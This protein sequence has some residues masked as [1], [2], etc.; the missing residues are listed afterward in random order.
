[1]EQKKGLFLVL[2][3]GEGTGKTTQAK[4]LAEALQKMGHEVLLTKEP[5]GDEGVCRD[6]RKTLLNPDYKGGMSPRAELLLFEADRA[7]HV[8]LV[9][10]PALEAGKIA[11]CDRYEGATEAYQCG[12]RGLD[13]V[14]FREI[15]RFA[16][17]ELAPDFTFWVDIDPA[18]GLQRN[19][20]AQKRDRFELEDIS[21]H[22]MVRYG[23]EGYFNVR[24]RN[25]W[26]K[27]DGMLSI[28]ELHAQILEATNKVL[29][30]RKA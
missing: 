11:I 10:R 12:G 21:F 17:K 1:M 19:K 20:D 9:I 29:A 7:Q 27:F 2:E 24:P 16:T 8:D 30:G 28:Q 22:K 25:S 23:Y 5:G 3:G 14:K 6:I 15:N 13:V 18:V 26:R 4:L